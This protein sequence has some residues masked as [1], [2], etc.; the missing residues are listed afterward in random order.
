MSKKTKWHTV[1]RNGDMIKLG[2]VQIQVV[3]KPHG[4]TSLTVEAPTETKITKQELLPGQTKL[5]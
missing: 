3:K 1:V 2:D 5:S 4:Y